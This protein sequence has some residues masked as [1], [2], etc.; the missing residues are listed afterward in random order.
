MDFSARILPGCPPVNVNSLRR[1]ISYVNVSGDFKSFLSYLCP[2]DIWQFYGGCDESYE[3]TASNIEIAINQFIDAVSVRDSASSF[4]DAQ[5]KL[6]TFGKNAA[7]VLS[8]KNPSVPKPFLMLLMYLLR[9]TGDKWSCEDALYLLNSCLAIRRED[10]AQLFEVRNILLFAHQA[11]SM[12]P[13]VTEEGQSFCWASILPESDSY[14]VFNKWDENK[15]LFSETFVSAVSSLNLLKDI[16]ETG[17][18]LLPDLEVHRHN[19]STLLLFEMIAPNHP[20]EAFDISLLCNGQSE[21]ILSPGF[22]AVIEECSDVDPIAGLKTVLV[23][24]RFVGDVAFF[25][26]VPPLSLPSFN[27]FGSLSKSQSSTAAVQEANL[28]EHKTVQEQEPIGEPMKVES[29]MTVEKPE[30]PDKKR[31]SPSPKKHRHKHSR[32]I[33]DDDSKDKEVEKNDEEQS[34]KERK[35]AASETGDRS[36]F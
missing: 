17:F 29:R 16:V 5:E 22:H 10:P 31:K 7:S 23:K 15:N 24:L 34:K 1:L 30:K 25:D 12:L 8:K 27:E 9:S 19:Q 36:C 20:P 18:D 32:T 2:S 35:R 6:K 13:R 21:Y 14:A 28:M 26:S 11:L 3:V 4:R 33:S